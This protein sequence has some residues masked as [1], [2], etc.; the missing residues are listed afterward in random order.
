VPQ[1]KIF[2][3]KDS[4]LVVEGKIYVDSY[5]S[6]NMKSSNI[7]TITQ[8]D[9]KMLGLFDAIYVDG[10]HITSMAGY[11]NQKII[12]TKDQLA[13]V[14]ASDKMQTG[15]WYNLKFVIGGGKV[16]VYANNDLIVESNIMPDF[17]ASSAPIRISIGGFKGYIDEIRVKNAL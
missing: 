10:T 15:T 13:A 6:L 1:D 12:F 8:G 2:P 16:Q 14:M 7:F 3:T 17:S 11:D 4:T 9:D 5:L